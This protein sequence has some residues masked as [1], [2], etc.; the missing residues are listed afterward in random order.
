MANKH[1]TKKLQTY[2][3]LFQINR[4]FKA[5]HT[6]CR[7]FEENGSLTEKKMRVFRG[8]VC[9]LQSLIS[10]DVLEDMLGIEVED[11]FEYGKVRIAW[12]HYLNP[13]RPAFFKLKSTP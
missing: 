6:H 13:K 8:L 11:S 12:E 2:H 4:A 10:S 3:S 5:I 1:L 9:E 7:I